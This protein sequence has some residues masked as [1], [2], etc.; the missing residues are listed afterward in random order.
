MF[1]KHHNA[2]SHVCT[3]ATTVNVYVN[4]AP[5]GDVPW[6]IVRCTLDRNRVVELLEL[7]EAKDAALRARTSTPHRPAEHVAV[8][9]DLKALGSHR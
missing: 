5:L 1:G 6:E 2:E 8:V 7:A 4:G 3:A 9:P